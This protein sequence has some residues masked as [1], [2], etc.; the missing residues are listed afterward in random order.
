MVADYRHDGGLLLRHVAL[1]E[2]VLRGGFRVYDWKVWD[3]CVFS[4]RRHNMAHILICCKAGQTPWHSSRL[5][6]Q[7]DYRDPVWRVPLKPD[8]RL[9]PFALQ[10]LPVGIVRPIVEK[11]CPPGGLVVDPFAGSGTVVREALRLGRRAIGYEI[12]SRMLGTIRLADEI[13]G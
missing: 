8:K 12:D 13:Y 2:A 7:D 3:H 9:G 10:V 6:T 4:L 1:A 5:V 11:Y